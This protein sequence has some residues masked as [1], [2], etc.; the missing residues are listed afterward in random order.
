MKHDQIIHLSL[1]F[2]QFLRPVA[3]AGAFP[4]ERTRPL[5]QVV[6][7]LLVKA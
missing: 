5:R 2:A 7:G 6:H 4:G 3:M 1:G